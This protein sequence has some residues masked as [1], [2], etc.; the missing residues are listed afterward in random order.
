MELE[1]SFLL[2]LLGDWTCYFI[3]DTFLESRTVLVQRTDS[4]SLKNSQEGTR[5]GT[6]PVPQGHDGV[7]N[8]GLRVYMERRWVSLTSS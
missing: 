2:K 4:V 1:G 8:R 6:F 5:H 3:S 7:G